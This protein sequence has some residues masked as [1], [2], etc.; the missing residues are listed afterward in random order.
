MVELDI[1]TQIEVNFLIVGHTHCSIDQFFSSISTRIRN[2][3]FIGSPLALKELL[4]L[5]LNSKSYKM[6]VI[7]KK[8]EVYYDVQ[9]ALIPYLN[10]DIT[11]MSIPHV[12]IIRKK[13]NRAICQYKLFSN[14]K[15]WLP[16]EPLNHITADELLKNQ[17]DG[18]GINYERLMMV[19]GK[20]NIQRHV[21]K[22]NKDPINFNP[23]QQKKFHNLVS[24]L[25]QLEE[26]EIDGINQQALRTNDLA[27]S[28]KQERRYT[29]GN[30]EIINQKFIN[31]LTENN[32][33]GYILFLNLS[34]PDLLPIDEIQA[35]PYH[36]RLLFG[37]LLNEIIIEESNNNSKD[38]L[39]NDKND[40]NNT[41][42]KPKVSKLV[43]IQ[44]TIVEGAKIIA[45]TARAVINETENNTIAQVNHN[46]Y[47]GT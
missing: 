23:E 46:N 7:V 20:D 14:R 4:Q 41:K 26:A 19:G 36:P 5:E 3:N 9:E 30:G 45:R 22:S 8:L 15:I 29:R 31:T 39:V 2:A 6:P 44:S 21:V 43:K 35:K 18:D 47:T 25:D 27:F 11:R 38:T 32:Q 28:G 42:K 40:I 16:E 33:R 34:N 17:Y 37:P 10:K 13:Y 1:F 24:L 12:F